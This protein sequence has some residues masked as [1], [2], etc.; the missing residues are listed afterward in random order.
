M[1]QVIRRNNIAAVAISPISGKW[2]KVYF[3]GGDLTTIDKAACQLLQRA[4]EAAGG[5][6]PG[7]PTWAGIDE[8]ELAQMGLGPADSMLGMPVGYGNE[9][10]EGEPLGNNLD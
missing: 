9:D 4:V 8:D 7:F 2:V 3:Q 10:L 5:L 6:P 1:N